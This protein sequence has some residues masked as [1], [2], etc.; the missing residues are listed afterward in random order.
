MADAGSVQFELSGI[1]HSF[2]IKPVQN[3]H[4]TLRILQYVILPAYL[5]YR[6]TQAMYSWLYTANKIIVG[7]L[8]SDFR[9]SIKDF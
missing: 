9:I 7:I 6:H 3:Q 8:F 4:S 5:L 1:R 2:L